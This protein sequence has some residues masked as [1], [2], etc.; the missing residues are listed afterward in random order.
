MK[1]NIILLILLVVSFAAYQEPEERRESPSTL[2]SVIQDFL[3]LS[4]FLR[5]SNKVTRNAVF[6]PKAIS[7]L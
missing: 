2:T 6:A 4:Q 3:W 1:L 5:F 7:C